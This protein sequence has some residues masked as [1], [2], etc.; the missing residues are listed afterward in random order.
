MFKK[1][2]FNHQF[3][4]SIHKNKSFIFNM[5]LEEKVYKFL[6]QPK[7]YREVKKKFGFKKKSE[8]IDVLEN[9]KRHGVPIRQKDDLYYVEPI[10]FGKR[11]VYEIDLPK[12]CCFAVVSDTHIGSLYSRL[13]LLS[14]FYEKAKKEGAEFFLHAGDLIDGVGVY[15]GQILEQK[16]ITLEKQLK[17][18]VKEYPN[19]GVKTFYINGNHDLKSIE[20]N[21]SV[22][23]ATYISSERDDLIHIG[24]YNAKVVGKG[25]EIDIELIHP[26]GAATYSKDYK[27]IKYIENLTGAEKPKLLFMG[28][29]HDSLY[30]FYRNVHAFKA[31]SFQDYTQFAKRKGYGNVLGGWIIEMEHDGEEVKKIKPIFVPYYI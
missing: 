9:L 2:T 6:K 13:D 31:G 27:L 10:G 5:S 30:I 18:V 28:H 24:D 1:K 14:D 25:T 29:Y 7:S 23:P 17:R 12:H 4:K 26:T 21:L 19:V 16:D 22:S 3:I 15:P 11:N 20:K 8:F